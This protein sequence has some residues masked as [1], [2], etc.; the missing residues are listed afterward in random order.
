MTDGDV[1]S[2][3]KTIAIMQPYL[4]PYIGYFQLAHSVDE[5]WLL[6]NVNFIRRGWMNR[7]NLLVNGNRWLYTIPVNS[8]PRDQLILHKTFSPDAVH[9]IDKLYGTLH[10]SYSKAPHLDRVLEL[11]AAVR[12]AIVASSKPA[13]FTETTEFALRKA[14]DMIG[15]ATP[16]YR[17]SS[18]NLANG[19]SGQGRILAACEAVGANRYVMYRAVAN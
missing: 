2:G 9:T 18:L 7:N 13:D 12:D 4:F 6:D 15:I 3:S 16:I 5:F 1:Q 8:G 10:T 17:V 19:L 14:F 11:V